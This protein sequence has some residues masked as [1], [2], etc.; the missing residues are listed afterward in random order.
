MTSHYVNPYKNQ[1]IEYINFLES[2]PTRRDYMIA[3]DGRIE[4]YPTITPSGR[5]NATL[6]FQEETQ[7]VVDWFHKDAT[8][9]PNYFK[10][11]FMLFA[12]HLLSRADVILKPS[13]YSHIDPV[14]V[15]LNAVSD[16]L[17]LPM[18]MALLEDKAYVDSTAAY[19]DKMARNADER[20]VAQDIKA[21]MGFA[22]GRVQEEKRKRMNLIGEELLAVALHPDRVAAWLATGLE[23]SDL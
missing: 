1:R 5:Q 18:G 20:R 6:R 15:M 17:L 19:L 16:V 4:Y 21:E 22:L 11:Q 3:L 14:R 10:F 2:T 8:Q 12:G 7:S 9:Y 13:I 23:M